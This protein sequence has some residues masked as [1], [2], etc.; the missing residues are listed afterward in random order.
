MFGAGAERTGRDASARWSP[1][2]RKPAAPHGNE[3][4]KRVDSAGRAVLE[5]R[6]DRSGDRAQASPTRSPAV[7]R[8]LGD[9]PRTSERP[10]RSSRWPGKRVDQVGLEVRGRPQGG[11][12]SS[13]TLEKRSLRARS[14]RAPARAGPRRRGA[15]AP[16]L[17]EHPSVRT[18]LPAVARGLLEMEAEDLVELDEVASALLEP[19]REALVELGPNR[20]R[21]PVIRGIAD[22]QVAEAKGVVA[23][24]LRPVRAGSA[25]CARVRPVAGGPSRP[26]SE[27]GPRLGGRSPPRPR[28]AR[29]PSAPSSR[30]GR[31]ARPAAPGGSAE[32]A[33]PTRLARPSP[34]SPSG[35]EGFRR[36]RERSAREARP[37]TLR[38]QLLDVL[39]GERL[40][41]ERDGPL[42]TPLDEA[43]GAPGRE[44]G[45]GALESSATCSTR[46]RNVSSPQ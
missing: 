34:P 26:R 8:A 21:Q 32:R 5:L 30:A 2:A 15:L 6:S 18:Q 23:G 35:R 41:P 42:R 24:Q 10:L 16:Q 44:A 36:P 9:G 27:P 11:T 33:R 22:E 37:A 31:G 28:R 17:G 39:S 12:S 46:S 1:S 13:R 45:S 25:P 29:A 38:D 40:E 3:R 19:V 4:L 43:R 7:A 20:F 14:R